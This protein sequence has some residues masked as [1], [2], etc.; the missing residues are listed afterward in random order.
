MGVLYVN[1]RWIDTNVVLRR[2]DNDYD[3]SKT[4]LS[5]TLSITNVIWI[6][7]KLRFLLMGVLFIQMNKF[8]PQNYDKN[9]YLQRSVHWSQNCLLWY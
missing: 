6:F 7:L 1:V 2:H 8:H 4:S 3:D 5:V 9:N